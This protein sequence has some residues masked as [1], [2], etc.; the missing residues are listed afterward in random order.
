[1]I[2]TL[3]VT[4]FTVTFIS[5]LVIMLLHNKYNSTR[6]EIEKRVENFTT[7]QQIKPVE[8]QT[9]IFK[10]DKL[11]EIPTFNRFLENMN[12]SKSLTRLLEH[13]GS[14]MKVG[15]LVLRMGVFGLVGF[16]VGLLLPHVVYR[17]LFLFICG[18][19]PLLQVFLDKI[20]RF[21]AFVKAFPD[22]LDMMTSAIRAGH[23]F[24]QAL[25]L[26]GEEA[27]E[28]VSTEFKKTFEQYN[29][30][31]NLRDALINMTTRLDSLDLKLFITAILL[32]RET[33]GNLAE[34]LEKISYTIRERFKLIGQIKTYTAQGR[35]SAWILGCLPIIFVLIISA[36]NP[37]Y[38]EPLFHD[39]LGHGLI[40]I[41]SILQIVGFSFIRKIVQIKY[42]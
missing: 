32:Q 3:I 1:M 28:P 11:S 42:E 16:L 8:V 17:W 7:E 10:S 39:K 14:Q 6:R 18:S 24:N 38:L 26:V 21:R 41:A 31:V 4:F 23:A 36:L 22:S 25:Q 34:I 29:L 2:W 33:G 27:S 40:V 30:G 13:A 20:Q 15:E 35:M 9:Q 5:S 19:F 37:G 12:V